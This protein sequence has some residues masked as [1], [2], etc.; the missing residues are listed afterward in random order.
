MCGRDL[1]PDEH[2][3]DKSVVT[4]HDLR[5]LKEKWESIAGFPRIR[6]SRSIDNERMISERKKKREFQGPNRDSNAGPLAVR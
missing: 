6:R 5:E 3:T 4:I 1:L 2:S